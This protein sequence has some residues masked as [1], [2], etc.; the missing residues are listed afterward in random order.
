[1]SVPTILTVDDS[2]VLRRALVELF[3][4]YECTL[5]QAADGEAGL[6]MRWP[7]AHT[8][9]LH[10]QRATSAR[11]DQSDLTLGGEHLVVVLKPKP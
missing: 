10:Y 4:P 8:L 6:D 1:M 3:R 7:D 2:S 9:E 11:L 5:L